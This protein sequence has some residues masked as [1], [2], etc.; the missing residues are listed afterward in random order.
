MTRIELTNI[1]YGRS[2]D[3]TPS[4]LVTFHVTGTAVA[5]PSVPG[6]DVKVRVAGQA[7]PTSVVNEA[8]VEFHQLALRLVEETKS[9]AT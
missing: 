8:K 2:D 5:V 4:A 3:D 1:D 7:D 9:W 6:F